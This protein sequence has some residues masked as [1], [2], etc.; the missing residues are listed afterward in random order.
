MKNHIEVV[1]MI[2]TRTGQLQF[3]IN[4]ILNHHDR[5]VSVCYIGLTRT[6]AHLFNVVI[7][8]NVGQVVITE[9][10]EP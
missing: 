10:K 4:K 8:R 3:E 1:E 2:V 7:C 6:N 5:V 9:R